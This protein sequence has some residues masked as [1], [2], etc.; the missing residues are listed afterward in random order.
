MA[1][2]GRSVFSRLARCT[3]DYGR[4]SG[5]AN[6]EPAGIHTYLLIREHGE[7]MVGANDS[8]LHVVHCELGVIGQTVLD[9]LERVMDQGIQILSYV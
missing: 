9:R 6:T 3:A 5:E 2:T 4:T 1:S 8:D 7:R